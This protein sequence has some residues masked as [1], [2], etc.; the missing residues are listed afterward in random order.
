VTLPISTVPISTVLVDTVT[1]PISSDRLGLTLPHEHLANRI[2]DGG[3]EP[4]PEYPEL[5]RAPVT[6]A[7]AQQLR[8]RPYA[9]LD[10]TVL[11][12][13][14]AMIDELRAFGAVGGRTVIDATPVGAG[15][16][17]SR[18]K[19]MSVASGIQVVLGG[20]WYL[21]RFHPIGTESWSLDAVADAIIAQYRPATAEGGIVPGLIGEIGVSPA[22]TSREERSLRGAA[23]AQR[24]LGKPLMVHLP[25]WERLGNR[26]LDIVLDEHGVD[27]RAVVLSHL[28]PSGDDPDYQR[29]LADRGVW[30]EFD[31]IGMPYEFPGEGRSP[32]PA[33]TAAAIQH[34]V[35]AGHGDQLLL[36][37]DLFLK[38]MLSKHGGNGLAYVPTV[39][40]ERLA[41]R[42]IDARPMMVDNPRALFEAAAR[43][44]AQRRDAR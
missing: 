31:M 21:D 12:D 20:G 42:G 30:C 1:G 43:R 11:D 32:A 4:D 35:D 8:N 19:R 9:S 18:V 6:F 17:P 27:P 29:S 5:Y 14:A 41:G 36:S 7:I 39:F 13:D 3:V 40:A 23:I 44:P 25:G 37:H 33:E 15:R 10:N 34:L 24:E 26:I 28:D 16:S 2:A 38:T 22:F